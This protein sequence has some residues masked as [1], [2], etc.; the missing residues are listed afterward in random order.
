M[1]VPFASATPMHRSVALLLV[2]L[3]AT[4]DARAGKPP[5]RSVSRSASEWI[6]GVPRLQPDSSPRARLLPGI[7][8]STRSFFESRT[9]LGS[10]QFVVR[11]VSEDDDAGHAYIFE[12]H[13]EPEVESEAFDQFENFP[14]VEKSEAVAIDGAAEKAEKD[15][16]DEEKSPAGD[17]SSFGWIIGGNDRLGMLE[18]VNRDLAVMNYSPTEKSTFRV[19]PGFV[20]RWLNGPAS[21]DLPPYLFNILI[22]VGTGFRVNDRWA[23]DAVITPSWNTDFANK[24]YKLFRLPWQTVASYKIDDEWKL[25]MGVTD[26]ARE[27]IQFLPVGGVTYT[28]LDGKCQFDLIF[29]RPKMAWKLS[30]RDEGRWGYVAGELGGGSFS[31]Q[32]ANTQPDIVTLRDYRLLFGLESRSKKGHA[33]RIEAGWVFGRAVEYQSGIGNYNPGQTAIIRVSSDF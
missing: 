22:D 14:D 18:W 30:E 8:P 26:L 24:G 17:Y 4:A 25:V 19:S 21:T 2:L 31:I 6:E 27:D 13:E 23:F 16:A 3:I 20:M 32:R 15:D 33:S 5:R 11:L 9:P 29:P 10:S 1:L 12:P 7:S 28:P